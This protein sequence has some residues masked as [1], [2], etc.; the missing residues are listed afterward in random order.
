MVAA[1]HHHFVEGAVLGVVQHLVD[2]RLADR[3][4]WSVMTFADAARS[5]RRSFG[6]ILFYLETQAAG[7]ENYCFL[8]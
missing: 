7:A 1:D 6:P 3:I 5:P 8:A 2:F 4:S